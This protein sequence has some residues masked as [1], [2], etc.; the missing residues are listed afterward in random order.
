VALISEAPSKHSRDGTPHEA[1]ETISWPV[2]YDK[3]G[4]R[5]HRFVAIVVVLVVVVA[6]LSIWMVPVALAPP[7]TAPANQDSGYPRRFLSTGDNHNV[8][9][10]GDLDGGVLNRVVRV[11][12][13]DDGLDLVDP[14]TNVVYR[15]AT[16]EEQEVIGSAP[17]AIDHF[18][19]PAD[20][21]LML[22]FDDGP[23]VTFTPEVLDILS[24]E[25]VPAT[26]FVIG[27]NVAANPDVFQRIIREGHMAGNHTLTHPSS[28]DEHTDVVN[29]EELIG[30]DRIMRATARYASPL[31]RIPKGDPDHNALALLQAQQLGFLHV[32][33]DIDTEDWRLGPGAELPVPQLDGHGH[34]VLMHD[35]GADR[36][37]TVRMLEKLIAQAKQ[38]G[39]SFST[40]A[41]LVSARYLPAKNIQPSLADRSTLLTSQAL[42]VVPRLLL[43]FLFWLGIGSLTVMSVVYLVLASISQYRQRRTPWP[44]YPD[45]RLPFVSVVLAA[46][47]EE[48]VI[49]KTL[50]ELRLTDYPE[51]KFEVVAV[52]DGST[53]R[54]LSILEDY[55][56]EW[57]QLRVVSQENSGK[58]AALNNGIEHARADSTIIIT[59]DADTLFRK[60]AIRMLV[61][62]FVKNT[63]GRRIGAVA[64]HVKVGNRRNI[65]TAWQSLEYISGICVTRM[66]E[67]MMNSIWIVPGAC[68]AW[69]REALKRIGGFRDDTMAEDT[70]ATL[71]LQRLGYDIRQEN[72]AIADT[73]APETMRALA[74]QR[75]RWTYGNIQA[76]CKH[77]GMLLR[78]KYGL[79][80]MVSMPYALLSLVVPLIFLPLALIAA[81]MNLAVGNWRSI[82]LFAAFVVIMHMIVSITA[83]IIARE[84]VWH[85]LVVPIYRLIYEPLRA[86][87]LYVSAYRL[88]RGTI[89]PW[90]KLQ[91]TNSTVAVAH[92]QRPRS[93]VSPAL[94]GGGVKRS[95]PIMRT[96][97]WRWSAR[98]VQGLNGHTHNGVDAD[99]RPLVESD[100]GPG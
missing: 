53:D 32:D 90:E 61:R 54:T 48:D 35:G 24:R 70:D 52:N 56:R 92:R 16:D 17:Y 79:L 43:G 3:S 69:R 93:G 95:P 99:G 14:F 89:V 9:M 51:S 27:E 10:V 55:A 2:F 83:I 18:G 40:V 84:R 59:L 41:P 1:S 76:L 31:F 94:A 98:F 19:R 96:G 100:A 42:W 68:S 77:R 85:L 30:A 34:V 7:W 58:P 74:K 72:A 11:V 37:A 28:F 5:F 21:Q 66:A 63:N 8:P 78:P 13:H 6:T 91:R 45:D 25:K 80:G 4:K 46:Y 86:Y 12:P 67:G 88:I 82:A 33:S 97:A 44:F 36:S 22:T 29:R 57:P 87:L 15:T 65:I 38:Q 49:A 71:T 39:Y 47:N 60:S 81:V 20:H 23:D 26:F 50:S 64:G 62:H 75:K 73:E